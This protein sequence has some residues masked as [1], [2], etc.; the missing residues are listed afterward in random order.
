MLCLN[1]VG[2]PDGAAQ[3]EADTL[4]YCP[5]GLDLNRQL[6]YACSCFMLTHI[7]VNPWGNI[8]AIQNDNGN[9]GVKF[10]TYNRLCKIHSLVL[11]PHYS[12]Q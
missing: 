3:N 5:N 12:I 11:S 2:D 1:S 7:R 10:S 6:V 9:V 8:A 4:Y